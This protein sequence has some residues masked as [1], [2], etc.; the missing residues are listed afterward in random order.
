[1]K[2]NIKKIINKSKPFDKEVDLSFIQK[3]K[4]SRLILYFFDILLISLVFLFF[5]LGGSA[6][7]N[8]FIC[9]TLDTNKSKLELFAETS[10]ESLTIILL[11]FTLLFYI[12]KIPSIVPYPDWNHIKFR[13]LSK[14]VIVA[15]SVVFGHERL[16]LKYQ[17]LLGI[18]S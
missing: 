9:Q 2:D 13:E 11:V 7:I 14:H 15:F 16:L 17:F 18:D 5:G 3:D 4:I 8:A 12:P 10:W 6:F 1:M